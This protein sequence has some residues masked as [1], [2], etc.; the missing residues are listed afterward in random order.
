MSHRGLRALVYGDVNLNLI[1]GSAVW[2]ASSAECLARSGVEVTVLLKAPIETDRLLRPL[3]VLPGVTLLAPDGSPRTPG[4]AAAE[5]QTLHGEQPFDLIVVRGSRAAGALVDLGSLQSVLWPYLTDIPQSVTSLDRERHV[6]LT[7]I[8]RGSRRVLCQTPE[9]RTFVE[10]VVPDA[11]GRTLLWEPIIPDTGVPLDARRNDA[12]PL[13]IGY[14]GKFAPAWN[15]DLML[16]LPA[17]L[18]ERGTPIELHMVGDKIQRDDPAFAQRMEQG[19]ASGPVRWHG[20]LDRATALELMATWDIGLSWRDRSLDSSLELSTK[21]LEYAAVGTPPLLN[22]TP[23][24]VRLLGEDYPLFTSPTESAVDVLATMNADRTFLQRAAERSR[25]AAEYY[26]MDAAVE[27]TR[28][29]LARAFPA[30]QEASGA[31]RIS[32]STRTL[33]VVVAGHD[34]KFMRGIADLL[35]AQPDIDVRI[36]EWSALAVHDEQVS[37]DLLAWADVIVCEW[38]G[39]NAVWYSARKQ[40]HQRLIIRLHRFELDA[41]WIRDVDPSSI[42][43]VVCVNNHYRQRVVTETDVAAEAVIVIPNAVDRDTF[44]RPKAPGAARVLGMLGIVPFRKRPDRALD[45]LRALNAERPGFLLSLK[46]GMPW[47]HSWIW[48]RPQER[49]AY[50]ALFDEI[51]QD[52][53]LRGAVVV[54]G[55]GGDVPAWLQRTGW[56]LSLSED[57]S[58]H[59]APA[60]GMAAGSVPVLMDWPGATDVYNAH[61]VHASESSIVEHILTVTAEGTWESR[62]AEARADFPDDYDLPAVAEQWARLLTEGR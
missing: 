47:E 34:L 53:A 62:S 37:R 51:A 13:R 39:P 56:V 42:E 26:R 18:A 55:H 17:Q 60:E 31:S 32:G 9:L 41:P 19:L 29:L 3:H 54:E 4:L 58:F 21:V 38:A 44:D 35:A 15:T 46:S 22:R 61:Y 28:H 45:I 16:D 27:R 6:E 36:D 59:L 33:R 12:D 30:A 40:A 11:A 2:L 8:V 7:R 43:R 57:E 10:A 20:G 50:R 5:V 1:D 24:H 48:R 23:M 25:A 14:A 49:V 52:P